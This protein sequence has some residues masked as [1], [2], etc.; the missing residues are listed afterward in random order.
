MPVII[1]F[2]THLQSDPVYKKLLVSFLLERKWKDVQTGGESNPL[3]VG[4][5]IRAI[6]R[7]YK[8]IFTKTPE[9]ADQQAFQTLPG[10]HGNKLIRAETG[11]KT[12]PERVTG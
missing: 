2:L 10:R 8:Q 6:N 12:R 7:K 11:R 4:P 9:A 3:T 1:I 5:F